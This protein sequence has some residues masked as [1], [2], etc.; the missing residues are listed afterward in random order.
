M[1]K[2]RE[3]NEKMN[4]KYLKTGEETLSCKLVSKFAKLASIGKERLNWYL[5]LKICV[6]K[7]KRF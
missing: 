3:G 7:E 2:C 5:G 1:L 4:S 6:G